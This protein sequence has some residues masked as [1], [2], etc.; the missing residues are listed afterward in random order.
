MVVSLAL[1]R[2][3]KDFVGADDLPEFQRSVRIARSEVGVSALDGSAKRGPQTFGVI[4]RKSAKQIIK[5]V[6][7]RA[8]CRI[9]VPARN[10]SCEFAAEYAYN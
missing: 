3:D 5:R 9:L 1:F 6:H 8:R 4:A 10:S 2:V 7:R